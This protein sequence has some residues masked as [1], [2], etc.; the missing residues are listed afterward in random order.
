M[1]AMGQ[2]ATWLTGSIMSALKPKHDLPSPR[3][4]ILGSPVNLVA[5][6]GFEP[7]AFG[8]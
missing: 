2:K 4:R 7:P 1:S 5:E 6:E 3:G 8:L